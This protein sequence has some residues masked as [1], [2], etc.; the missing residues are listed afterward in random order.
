MSI[1]SVKWFT[2]LRVNYLLLFL[3]S[4]DT[5]YYSY[6][7]CRVLLCDNVVF[8]YAPTSFQKQ[9]VTV[10]RRQEPKAF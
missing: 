8:L 6:N 4:K 3:S 10:S 5:S 2:V 7:V 1:S 9:T